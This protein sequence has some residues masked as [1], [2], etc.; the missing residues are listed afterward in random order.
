MLRQHARL[1]D[2]R[3]C[4][5]AQRLHDAAAQDAVLALFSGEI[6]ELLDDRRREVEAPSL[7]RQAVEHLR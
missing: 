6:S 2:D 7:A 3:A 1:G 5:A 4:L